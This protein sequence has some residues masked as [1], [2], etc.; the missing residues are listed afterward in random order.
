V[1]ATAAI[2]MLG[3]ILGFALAKINLK[4]SA[5][6]IKEIAESGSA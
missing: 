4:A 6:R 1:L 2:G 3:K 5:G